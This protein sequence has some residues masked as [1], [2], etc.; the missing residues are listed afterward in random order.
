MIEVIKNIAAFIGCMLSCI[1]LLALIFKPLRKTIINKIAEA[2][3]KPET[4][5]AINELRSQIYMMQLQMEQHAEEDR[6]CHKELYV[7]I[8]SDAKRK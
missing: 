8:D 6:A 5:N 2:A 1:S 7:K 3:D 4:V